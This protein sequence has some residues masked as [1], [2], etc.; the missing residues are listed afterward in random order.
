MK[1]KSIYLIFLAV[2][3]GIILQPAAQ[4]SIEGEINKCGLKM[5]SLEMS[6]LINSGKNVNTDKTV[7][8]HIVKSGE[9]LSII[10]Q[11]YKTTVEKIMSMN[12]AINNRDMILVGQRLVIN[13]SVKSREKTSAHNRSK[14]YQKV[15]LTKAEKLKII[16]LAAART[17][18][19]WEILA[20]LSQQ[21]SGL[22]KVMIGDGGRS[23][24]PYHI[25]LPSHPSVSA[26]KAMDF[27]W[28]SNWA[29]DYLI[30]LGAKDDLFTALRLWNGSIKN[31]KTLVHAT[32][33]MYLAVNEYGYVG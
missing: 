17:G 23:R 24:G 14:I 27:E 1:K 22:G 6:V 7:T 29:A 10:S 25:H 15:V 2:F 18:L 11:R 21:E 4:A 32:R 26:E 8:V 28:S 30:T 20:G 9:T 31:K 13:A 5:S 33:V 12:L 19:P 3:F 16:E